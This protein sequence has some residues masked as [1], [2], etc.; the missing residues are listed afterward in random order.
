MSSVCGP[1]LTLCVWC[2]NNCYSIPLRTSWP[3]PLLPVRQD[4]GGDSLSQWL[5]FLFSASVCSG[6]SRDFVSQTGCP[7]THHP[8]YCSSFYCVFQVLKELQNSSSVKYWLRDWNFREV[9]QQ[10]QWSNPLNQTA[11]VKRSGDLA[12]SHPAGSGWAVMEWGAG[13][14]VLPLHLLGPKPSG[15]LQS[16]PGRR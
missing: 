5:S 11:I 7:F 12:Q 4:T 10:L 16:L 13:R 6:T 3:L 9:V 8:S 2:S 1:E 14:P 15:V